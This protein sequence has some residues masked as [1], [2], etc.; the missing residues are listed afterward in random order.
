MSDVPE[1]CKAAAPASV[2]VEPSFTAA[3]ELCLAANLHLLFPV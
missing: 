2:L 3:D 1:H